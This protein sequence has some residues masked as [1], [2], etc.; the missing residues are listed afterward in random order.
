MLVQTLSVAERSAVDAIE[1]MPNGYG[2]KEI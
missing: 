2:E 1:K